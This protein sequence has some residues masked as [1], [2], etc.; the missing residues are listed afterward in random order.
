MRPYHDKKRY[1]LSDIDVARFIV[2]GYYLVRPR[3]PKRL[4][5]TIAKRLDRLE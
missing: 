2:N 3:C 5:E 1:L 4:H